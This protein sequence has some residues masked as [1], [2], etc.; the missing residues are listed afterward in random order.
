MK[1]LLLIAALA[2]AQPL[3]AASFSNC[4]EE[5]QLA[6]RIMD[7]RQKGLPKEWVLGR[8]VD[9]KFHKWVHEAYTFPVDP[10]SAHSARM[11]MY[12]KAHG[13]CIMKLPRGF[14]WD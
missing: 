2:M 12:T 1:K 7:E 8:V 4:E 3:M 5:G 9:P 10:Y 6:A 11:L 14:F 13:E